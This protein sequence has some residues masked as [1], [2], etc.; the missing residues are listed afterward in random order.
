MGDAPFDRAPASSYSPKAP[1]IQ[2]AS[3]RSIYYRMVFQGITDPIRIHPR[4]HRVTHHGFP[5]LR[6][7]RSLDLGPGW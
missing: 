7:A 5:A 2:Q 6:A 1:T 3:Y 4:A